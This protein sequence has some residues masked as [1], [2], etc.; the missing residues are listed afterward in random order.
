MLRP[1]SGGGL[2]PGR[3]RQHPQGRL[4]Q[5]RLR[6]GRDH[7]ANV[8]DRRPSPRIQPAAADAAAQSGV[9]QTIARFQIFL[10][11][12]AALDHTHLIRGPDGIFYRI[13][14]AAG[15]GRIDELQT[16]DAIQWSFAV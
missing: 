14:S 5:G 1:Q 15:A 8:E 3:Y 16:V 7:L 4:C 13:Q 11:E 9:R 2:W 10:E 12:D 6:R